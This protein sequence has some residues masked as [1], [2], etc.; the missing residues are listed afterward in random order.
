VQ[1]FRYADSS[2]DQTV[3]QA[4]PQR[5]DLNVLTIPATQLA[6][7]EVGAPLMASMICLGAT[8]EMTKV[9]SLDSARRALEASIRPGRHR[10]IPMN[11]K[12]LEVGAAFARDRLGEKVPAL[13]I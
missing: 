8:I 13:A 11:M 12:A 6:Q 1:R 5:S 10:F 4:T 7:E 9:V 2:A 3:R